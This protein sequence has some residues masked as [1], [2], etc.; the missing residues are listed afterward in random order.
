VTRPSSS[1]RAFL[2]LE[3]HP[4]MRSRILSAVGHLSARI[5]GPRWLGAEQF[6]LTL[7]FLGEV[8]RGQLD[9]VVRAL[10]TVVVHDHSLVARVRGLGLFPER[11]APRTLWIGAAVPE[12]VY[13]IQARS[14][15]LAR[16]VGIAPEAR[17]FRPHITLARWREQCARPTLPN[18]DLGDTGLHRLVLYRSDLALSGARYTALSTVDLASTE[19][20]A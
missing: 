12:A 7:R 10:P 1:V 4:D 13:D 20:G 2:A 17:P 3:L 8:Q 6:H 15:R 9:E 19:E 16:R 18:L 5:A 11:G 14:E